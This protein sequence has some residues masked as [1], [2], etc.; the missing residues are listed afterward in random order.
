[1][2]C[3]IHKAYNVNKETGKLATPNTPPELVERRVY[4]IYP[5]EAEDWAREAEIAEPPSEHD[6]YASSRA[7]EDIAILQPEMFGYVSELVEIKGNAR[8][9]VRFWKLD[10]GQGLDPTEWVQIGGDHPYEVNGD[11]M[12]YWDVAELD[13]LFTLRLTAIGHD[14]TVRQDVLQVTVDNKPPSMKVNHPEEGMVF[15]KEDDEWINIQVT[16]GDNVSMAGVDFELDGKELGR[17]TVS[18]Y[19]K[20]WTIV[21]SDTVPRLG[22]NPVGITLPIT[23]TDGTV[24]EK[25]YLSRTEWATRTIT[26]ADGTFAEEEYPAVQVLYDP[27]LEQTTMWFDGGMGIIQDSKGYTETHLIRVIAVDAAGNETESEPI[28][29]YVIHKKEEEET[30]QTAAPNVAM[31][32]PVRREEQ[33]TFPSD[34]S[35][36]GFPLPAIP[37]VGLVFSK[38]LYDRHKARRKRY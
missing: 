24:W 37:A 14:D 22:P 26:N 27:E 20:S 9:N 30:E 33:Q 1:M 35:A 23:E 38:P 3:D 34:T 11:L 29:V 19:N 15:T 16:A 36:G 8:N 4:E 2:S 25:F 7:S 21:M 18:P 5:P 6:D 31:I 17:S 10:F 12:E 32:W 13:G 28:R